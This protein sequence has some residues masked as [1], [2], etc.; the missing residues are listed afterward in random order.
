VTTA[1]DAAPQ[2]SAEQIGAFEEAAITAAAAAAQPELPLEQ[3]TPPSKGLRI[4]SEATGN[5]YEIGALIGEGAFGYVYEA[6]DVWRN[7]LAVKILKPRGTYE[8]VKAAANQELAKLLA[9]RHPNVTHV[10][11]AFEF[12]HTFYLI[13]ERCTTPLIGLFDLKPL[14]GHQWI[15]PVARCLL[16]AVHFLHTNGYVHQDIHFG[17][18]FASFHRSE[19][20]AEQTNAIAFKLADFGIA[21]LFEEVDAENTM[22]NP[23]MFPPEYLNKA[24]GPLDHRVDVYH[25]GLLFLQLLVGRQLQF[26]NDEILEGLPRRLAEQLEEPFK[27]AISGALRR[28]VDVRTRNAMD[29]WQALNTSAG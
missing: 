4:T 27:T 22:L 28:H 8:Q 10:F 25:C 17:N 2:P 1:S 13:T 7:A 14:I 26:T 3:F 21:K 16:Q 11:D 18:I 9:L 5:T 12:Q 29:L 15:L 24:L 19:M 6:E 20:T 23:G